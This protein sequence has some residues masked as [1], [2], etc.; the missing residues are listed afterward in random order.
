MRKS[1]PFDPF[2]MSTPI[3]L[4][5]GGE[6]EDVEVHLLPCRVSCPGNAAPA[7]V[8][9]FFSA[10]IRPDERVG[11]F[12]ASF[13]GRPLK[14]VCLAV[15][16]GYTGIDGHSPL[17]LST[18]TR[19]CT[20]VVLGENA[21]GSKALYSLPPSLPLF[22]SPTLDNHLPVRVEERKF[23]KVSSFSELSYWNLDALASPD[24]PLQR[25]LTWTSVSQ[26]VHV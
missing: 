8:K 18:N 21:P 5:V 11:G 19:L 4:E 25:A 23:E 7:E 3:A 10:C 20:G 15:P 1:R 17:S 6:C 2:A 14:G 22:L 24:D 13:R 9:G 12:E 16:E 26:M